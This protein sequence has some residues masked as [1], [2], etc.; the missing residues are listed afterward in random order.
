M[1]PEKLLELVKELI[2]F[3]GYK[4]NMEKI[5]YIFICYE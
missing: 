2:K 4:F 1:P 3:A 5:S